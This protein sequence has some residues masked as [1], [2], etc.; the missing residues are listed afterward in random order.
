[1]ARVAAGSSKTAGSNGA[2]TAAFD[3]PIATAAASTRRLIATS[4]TR[5][6]IDIAATTSLPAE[7]HCLSD[8]DYSA[9]C[10]TSICM[11]RDPLLSYL[12]VI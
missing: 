3:H 9:F 5:V 1:M 2:A 4:I 10:C 8:A 7:A 6:A 11:S 12:H